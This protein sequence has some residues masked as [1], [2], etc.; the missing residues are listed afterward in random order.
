MFSQRGVR[1]AEL[2]SEKSPWL[3]A[4]PMVQRVSSQISEIET[5]YECE[6]S[7]PAAFPSCSE[8]KAGQAAE[9]FESVDDELLEWD[10]PELALRAGKGRGAKKMRVSVDS[11]GS[12]A[13]I[14]KMQVNGVVN[15]GVK[16][17]N[18]RGAG[19]RGRQRSWFRE[20][21]R[22]RARLPLRAWRHHREEIRGQSSL[23]SCH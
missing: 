9:E 2:R 19:L 20:R 15:D 1:S 6:W 5:E 12:E 8:V 23:G 16:R 10:P 11:G 21:L 14:T 3:P 4:T 7:E 22:A 18:G 17:D 13:K